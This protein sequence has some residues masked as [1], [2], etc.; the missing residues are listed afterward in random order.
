MNEGCTSALELTP[1]D[2]ARDV[3]VSGNP[4]NGDPVNGDRMSGPPSGDPAAEEA[5]RLL[6]MLSTDERLRVFAAV[7]LGAR[8]STQVSDSAGLPG[9]ETAKALAQ[10]ERESLVE[11]S[12][13]GWT[14]RTDTLRHAVAA[15]APES[16]K[17]E[18]Y[19]AADASEAAVFRAFL[20]G[21]RLVAMPA[22]RSKRLVVLEHFARVFEPGRYYTEREVSAILRAFH[23]DYAMLRRHLVDEGFLSRDAS[24]Y[25]RS[26]GAVDV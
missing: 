26:G 22:Q 18:E 25:W 8:T 5:V 11:R 6:G 21:G 16:A 23:D 1:L 14:P 2:A 17:D 9:K 20:R 24:T 3:P 4:V 10:L 13:D 15:A 12:T 7:V 19:G